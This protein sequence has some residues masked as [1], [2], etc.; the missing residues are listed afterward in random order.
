MHPFSFSPINFSKPTPSWG[1]LFPTKIIPTTPILQRPQLLRNHPVKVETYAAVFGFRQQ[2]GLLPI[3]AEVN[4]VECCE[5][6]QTVKPFGLS[7]WWQLKYF[8][9]F[10]PYLGK[11]TILTNIFQMD[12]NHQLVCGL[13]HGNFFNSS[14]IAAHRLVG[15]RSKNNKV[16]EVYPGYQAIALKKLTAL[17]RFKMDMCFFRK[18]KLES[19]VGREIQW[20]H[21]GLGGLRLFSRFFCW[22]DFQMSLVMYIYIMI[23]IFI[24]IYI[25]STGFFPR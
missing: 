1:C 3:T 24:Y 13:F 20:K 18:K 11:I 17:Q 7:R 6:C 19:H 22:E 12:W 8:W 4:S 5:T 2:E 21:G 14:T 15:H 9:N 23:Y 25:H 16:V 10:H